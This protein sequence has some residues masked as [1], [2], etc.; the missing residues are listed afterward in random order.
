MF[1]ADEKPEAKCPEFWDGGL[2]PVEKTAPISLLPTGPL[3]FSLPSKEGSSCR[4][5]GAVSVPEPNTTQEGYLSPTQQ[6]FTGTFHE[7]GSVKD[8][9]VNSEQHKMF[10]LHRAWISMMIAAHLHRILSVLHFTWCISCHP[11]KRVLPYVC[12]YHGYS[13][14]NLLMPIL[15]LEPLRLAEIK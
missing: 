9:G 1:G 13:P 4:N 7:P 14:G 2:S 12:F 3:H 15:L 6:V 11:Q 5:D 10:P 8:L